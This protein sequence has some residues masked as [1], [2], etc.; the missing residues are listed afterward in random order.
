MA[1]EDWLDRFTKWA[2]RKHAEMT[3]QVPVA[4]RGL[5]LDAYDL[6][7]AEPPSK[8]EIEA[9]RARLRKRYPFRFTR[10]Q[11]D[12]R[13]LEEQHH[14]FGVADPSDMRWYV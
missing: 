11:A 12:M 1:A 13:W 10:L 7:V 14:K 5:E 6:A 8:N 4:P 3:N 2:E 9:M